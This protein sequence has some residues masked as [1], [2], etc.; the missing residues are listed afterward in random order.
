MKNTKI[1]VYGVLFAWSSTFVG[2]V[3]PHPLHP[4]LLL[5]RQPSTAPAT[6]GYVLP[7][8]PQAGTAY[9]LP[10]PPGRPDRRA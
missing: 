2:M 7:R 5:S 8:P 3:T 6:L 4:P 9:V 1:I 10:R